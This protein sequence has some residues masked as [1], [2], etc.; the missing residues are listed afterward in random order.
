[1]NLLMED[2]TAKF[3]LKIDNDCTLFTEGGDS[4]SLKLL[5]VTSWA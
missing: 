4:R 1:M 5:Q 2:I 3:N